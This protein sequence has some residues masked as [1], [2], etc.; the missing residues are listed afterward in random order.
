MVFKHFLDLFDF[1][2]ST[3]DFLYLFQV[4][5]HVTLGHI[6]RSIIQAFDITR[7]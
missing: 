1:K 3:S 2:D 4:S 7:L 5:S 6:P